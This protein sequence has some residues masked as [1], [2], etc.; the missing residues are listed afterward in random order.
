MK[1]GKVMEVISTSATR[2]AIELDSFN[3]NAD[4]SI[5]VIVVEPMCCILIGGLTLRISERRK[6]KRQHQRRRRRAHQNTHR[7]R[8]AVIIGC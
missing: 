5:D 2:A 8:T 4:G 1:E 6:R 3:P 7:R